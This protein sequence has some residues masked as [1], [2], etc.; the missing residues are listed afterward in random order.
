MN[1]HQPLVSVVTPVRNGERYIG[2]CIESVL[3]QTYEN[4]EYVIV[5]NVS[6]DGTLEIV[7]E[8]A[9]RDSRIRVVDN[10]ESLP[11]LRN[12]NHAMRQISEE[13]RYCKVVHADDS[14][15]PTCIERMVAV[16]EQ[17]PNVGI[18]GSARLSGTRVEPDPPITSES[19]VVLD[20][21]SVGRSYLTGG[22]YI[23][24]SPTTTL[25][26][27]D[28]IRSKTHFYNERNLHADTE[29]CLEIASRCDF[30]YL[31]EVLTFTRRHADSIS[32][33]VVSR[34]TTALHH[35]HVHTHFA[36][37][38]FDANEVDVVLRRAARSY[39]LRV[40][41]SLFVGG[42]RLWPAHRDGLKKMGYSMDYRE[43]LR[44]LPFLLRKS[45][46]PVAEPLGLRS[47]NA[48]G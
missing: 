48:F 14:L 35:Y 37:S 39:Y 13:S 41:K 21:R 8:Y 15:Y 42:P 31:N 3:N 9:S 47:E 30:G 23:F 26:R 38:F 4:W 45:A 1:D 36:P 29:V 12:W 7:R 20:G 46:S 32:S 44:A 19:M 22:P 25:L 40:W 28:L 43:F 27:S 11:I 24:G 10:T 18:V 5:N 16:A 17:F 6:T 34:V 2:E 33:T